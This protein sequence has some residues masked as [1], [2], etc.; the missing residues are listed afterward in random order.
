MRMFIK[1]ATARFKEIPLEIKIFLFFTLFF[2]LM[3]CIFYFTPPVFEKTVRF[4]VGFSIFVVFYF[5]PINYVMYFISGQKKAF[6]WFPFLL[7]VCLSSGVN[8]LMNAIS[9]KSIYPAY[10]P[11]RLFFEI[12]FPT[13]WIAIFTSRSVL[14]WIQVKE[15][16][17]ED[18][19][20]AS[21]EKG[22]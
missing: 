9:L 21:L 11:S 2:N 16:L 1:A 12:I 8:Y 22:H 17:R 20:G 13:F 7:L 19:K 3:P 18:V 15:V 5:S 14:D 4:H 6:Y 10:A